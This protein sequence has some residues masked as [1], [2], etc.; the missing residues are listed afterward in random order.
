[1]IYADTSA[2]A[3]LITVERETVAL[4]AW[5][6][7]RPDQ[8]IATNSVGVVELKR[9]GARL[10]V[11]VAAAAGQLL[12]SIDH[13]DL[14]GATYD[15][16]AVL[17]PTSLRTLDALHVASATQSHSVTAFVTYDHRMIEAASL[18]GLPVVTPS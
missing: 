5:I 15:L 10:G 7:E 6:G 17:S 16:A 11:A 3:K 12:Q 8:S 14:N 4:R 18:V 13:L 2:L 1:L 9:M